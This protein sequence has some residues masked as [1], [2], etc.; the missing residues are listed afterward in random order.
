M[1][2]NEFCKNK[3]KIAL[4]DQYYMSFPDK[5][6]EVF[7]I[8]FS[9]NLHIGNDMDK[10]HYVYVVLDYNTRTWWNCD[11][12]IITQYPGNAMNVYDDL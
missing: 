1:K 3:T 11:D 5:H 7:Y 4:P 10:G 8:I 2:K 12:E 9:I 6:P